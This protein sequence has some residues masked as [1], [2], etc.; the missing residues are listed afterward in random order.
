M[1]L[2]A[3]AMRNIRKSRRMRPS[4]VA[5]AMGLPVRT[6]EHLEAGEGR[7]S[8]ERIV[9]FAKVTNSDPDALLAVIQIDSPEFAQRCADNKLMRI[10]MFHIRELNEELGDDIAYLESG[11]VLGAMSRLSKELVEH[12]R[13]RD[14]YA[15]NWFQEKE[16]QSRRTATSPARLPKGRLAEG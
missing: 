5:K 4:E 2:L 16:A 6:Y 14:T 9:K 11:V 1:A 13:K 12:V 7:M 3:E 10:M 15:E 8:Y